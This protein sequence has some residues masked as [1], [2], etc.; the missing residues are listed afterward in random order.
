MF[1]RIRIGIWYFKGLLIDANMEV[2]AVVWM[3]SE[4]SD[5]GSDWWGFLE[6]WEVFGSC[7]WCIG[8]DWIEI[9]INLKILLG[10]ELGD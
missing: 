10:V 6:D 2:G 5:M 4:S 7:G 9:E 8:A 1:K 3:T